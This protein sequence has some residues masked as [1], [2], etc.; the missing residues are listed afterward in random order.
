LADLFGAG[1]ETTVT[2]LRFAL[3]YLCLHQQMQTK[4]VN[5]IQS[6]T[7]GERVTMADRVRG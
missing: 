4:V 7:G 6:A 1:Q 5:E 2:T 3:L